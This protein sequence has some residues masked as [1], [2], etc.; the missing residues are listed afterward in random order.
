MKY[1][2]TDVAIISSTVEE[3]F[4][5]R[6]HSCPRNLTSLI[7]D[8]HTG[9]NRTFVKTGTIRYKFFKNEAEVFT[10]L[11][12]LLKS[13]K[14]FTDLKTSSIIKDKESNLECLKE[15]ECSRDQWHDYTVGIDI[16]AAIKAIYTSIILKEQ[17]NT[18][19]IACKH[20]KSLWYCRTCTVRA[21]NKDKKW[22]KK[23][24]FK[25]EA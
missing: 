3:L 11:D 16:E 25:F 7:A 6:K 15:K 18:S 4:I 20:R 24:R 1:L 23:F 21:R 17:S 22:G 10:Y 8:M 19:C 5:Q 14:R 12:I 2:I 13:I 9:I